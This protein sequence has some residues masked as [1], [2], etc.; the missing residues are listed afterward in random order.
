MTG[1]VIMLIG[2]CLLLDGIRR[3]LKAIRTAITQG[4]IP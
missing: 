1:V 2:V 3:E 4:Q